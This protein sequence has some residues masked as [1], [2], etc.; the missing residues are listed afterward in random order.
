MKSFTKIVLCAALFFSLSVFATQVDDSGLAAILASA[1]A[2]RITGVA[3]LVLALGFDALSIHLANK[4]GRH[5]E[6]EKQER[7]NKTTEENA[8]EWSYQ[9]EEEKASKSSGYALGSWACWFGAKA[10]YLTSALFFGAA[11]TQGLKKEMK[12]WQGWYPTV[13]DHLENKVFDSVDSKVPGPVQD[14]NGEWYFT[15]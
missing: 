9:Q 8:S 12:G 3:S 6:L 13:K 5:E 14:E 15:I 7:K 11:Y 1:T 10:G 2:K 4:S